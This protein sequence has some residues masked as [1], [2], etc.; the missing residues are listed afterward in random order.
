MGRSTRSSKARKLSENESINGGTTSK[1][2]NFFLF[3]LF[4]TNFNSKFLQ[5]LKEEKKGH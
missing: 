2:S 3:F 4:Y 5:Q 1:V